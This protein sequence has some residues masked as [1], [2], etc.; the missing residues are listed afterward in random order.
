MII[1]MEKSEMIIGIILV[2]GENLILLLLLLDISINIF[3][4]ILF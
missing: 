3:E 2:H 1:K 4:G